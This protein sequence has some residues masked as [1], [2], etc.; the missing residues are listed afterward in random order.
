M[1]RMKTRTGFIDNRPSTAALAVNF[2]LNTLCKKLP[3]NGRLQYNS[4]NL[5]ELRPEIDR[6]AALL[7]RSDL[8]AS[9]A[10][11]QMLKE[12]ARVEREVK[13]LAASGKLGYIDG[14]RMRAEDIAA[15]MNEH[16]RNK[17][18][19]IQYI[20]MKNVDY[21]ERLKSDYKARIGNVV[22]GMCKDILHSETHEPRRYAINDKHRKIEAKRRRRARTNLIYTAQSAICAICRQESANFLKTVQ[23]HEREISYEKAYGMAAE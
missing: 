5:K 10:H 19:P 1:R 13:G 18:M 16:T 15:M 20:D 12:L 7:I 21:F 2:E 9:S 11:K 23:Q 17:S 22:L 4:P 8:R 3:K 14:K 6:I